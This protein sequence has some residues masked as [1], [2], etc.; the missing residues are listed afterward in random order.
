MEERSR[1]SPSEITRGNRPL[2]REE[3]DFR[4]PSESRPP[5]ADKEP[6]WVTE[7][8][9]LLD[10]RDIERQVAERR[11]KKPNYLT[12]TV[13]SGGGGIKIPEDIYDVEL[14]RVE[15]CQM[16]GNPK[17]AKADDPDPTALK[18]MWEWHFRIADT[19]PDY[20]GTVIRALSS[21]SLHET[22]KAYGW[23]G[24]IL[25]KS[26]PSG[27]KVDLVALFGKKCRIGVKFNDKGFSQ[28]T[29]VFKLS[30]RASSER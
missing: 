9:E 17:Y 27:D 19:D 16:P 10:P 13:T 15:E 2:E 18:D 3:S 1:V 12:G 11:A 24:A 21:R 30:S 26:V 23:V 4:R 28:V 14:L 20:K 25:G 7:G 6:D 8:K 5:V 29:E 22:S